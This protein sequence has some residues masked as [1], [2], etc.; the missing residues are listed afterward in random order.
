MN[1]VALPAP[2][3]TVPRIAGCT[4]QLADTG[5]ALPKASAPPAVSRCVERARTVA[6]AGAI[7]SAASGPGVTVVVCVALVTPKADAVSTW[8][9]ARVSR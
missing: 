6:E 7:V 5:T 3:A 9:P 4:D 2:G 8:L 1:V